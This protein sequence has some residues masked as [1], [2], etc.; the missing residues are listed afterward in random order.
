MKSLNLSN[1]LL[2]VIFSLFSSSLLAQVKIGGT[3]KE[4]PHPSAILDLQGTDKGFLLPRLTQQ[5]M[6]AIKEPANSL[7]IFNTDA[8]G[9]YIYSSEQKEW[10]PLMQQV[11]NFGEG[12]CEWEFDTA[13]LK[14]FLVRGYPLNDSIYYNTKRKKFVFADK[15]TLG[16]NTI[17]VDEQFPGKFIVKGTA[18]RIYND[19]AS[20]NFPSLTL[21]NFL[22]E[23]DNDSFAL[24]NPGLAFYNGMRISTQLV[25]TAT[26]QIGTIRSLLLQVNHTGADSVGA[27]T[28][29]ASN[30]FIDGRGATGSFNGFQNNMVVNDSARSN[31]GTIT[32]YRNNITMSSL[33]GGR[34]TGNVYGYF[35]SMAGFADT[36]GNKLVN[37]NAYGVFLNNVNIA[38]PKRNY[39]F[40]SNKG[41]NR[42]GDSTLITDGFTTSPR[43]VLDVNATSAMILPSGNTVQRPATGITAMFRNNTD[44]LAPE[45]FDGA[46]WK[47]L[48]TGGEEWKFDAGT[49]R[50]NLV[51]GLTQGDSVYYNIGKRKFV[52]A[53][54]RTFGNTT[55]PLDEQF[56]G[57][58]F[59]KGT[60]SQM[61]NDSNSVNF[62]SLTM[63]NFLY[64]V[65]ND[66]FAIAN[67]NLAF[68]NGIRVST[69]LLPTATQKT[70]TIRTLNLQVNHTG[71]DSLGSITSVVSNAF[72]DGRGYTGN[73][74]GIQN[75]MV[76]TDS[77]RNN[78][79]TIF[80]Y[81]N[82]ITM[83]DAAG[84]RVNGNV[85]GYFGNMAGF[86][87]SVG[88][89]YV[90]GNAYGVFLNNVAIAAPKRNYAFY[91]NKGH[92]RFA[93]S[94]LITDGFFTSPRAVLDINATSAMIIPSGTTLQRPATG[95]TAMFRNNT[96]VKAPEFFDG[97]AWQSLSTGPA[98]WKFDASTNK[99]NLVRGLPI[100]DTIFYSTQK[101]QFVFSDRN[102]NTNSLGSD[103]PVESF[104][105]KYT[106]KTTASKRDSSQLDG[107][108]MNIVYEVDN[109]TSST[110]YNSLSTS[111]VMNP[112]AFQKADQLSGITNTVIHA[113]NDSMQLV[114]GLL[115]TARN[116]GNGKSGSITGI[117]NTVRIQNGNG[118]NT[119][120][121]VGFRN[122]M[123]RSGATAGRVTGNVYGWLGT[124]SGF[125][126]NVDGSMYG[127]FLNSVTGAGPRKNYAYYSN[128]GLNRLG[129]SLLVTDGSSITP[130][131]VLD[132]NA[133]SAMIVPTGTS[134]QRPA[135]VVTGMVRYNTEN[136]GRLESYSGTA[137]AGI[138]SG[139]I[140]IDPPNIPVNSGT[141]VSFAFAGATVGS[142]VSVSPSSALPNG[143]IIAWARV[144]A[145]NTIEIRFE[146]NSGAAVNPPSIGYNIRVIQ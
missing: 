113:G 108:N 32:G 111:A 37:G 101:R 121:M 74:S 2:F 7:V 43:A 52:F 15:L 98:E 20:L 84:G 139:G 71:A 120:E 119:G 97:L 22:F 125:T 44:L 42:F 50:V 77:A 89:R 75:N 105:A 35:G 118:N 53:D 137:W 82:N 45:Y 64:E 132:V 107:A 61:F 142:V 36:L 34:V 104:G 31:I 146:N 25:P 136:G 6:L 5:Q 56:P 60:A 80:G 49:N 68:Y 130:R 38:A 19:S 91:S 18:S 11:P 30:G 81:R 17:P 23:V 59:F 63:S 115:N 14:V 73:F 145:A 13:T 39:A 70:A 47:Q 9:V 138:I 90:N 85:Y 33:A 133:T 16:N 117:Q 109:T 123:G 51:R 95:I 88:N 122:T 144:S 3:P 66:P 100:N 78:I 87:D 55:V 40:Y 67:P 54:K 76:I 62:P 134:A 103:F 72:I 131:A 57:K 110:V 96:D 28:S 143:I 106:F 27:V 29:L 114:Y 48:S 141:T 127:I 140:G 92:N 26:Q 69:Q 21:S 24:A 46:V 58:Y 99:V 8:K 102:T 126:N 4:N 65:D 129:D 112:K 79:G 86:A 83:S 116:S 93:D 135:T 124:F 12:N 10:L 94:T 128:K 1:V 41:H